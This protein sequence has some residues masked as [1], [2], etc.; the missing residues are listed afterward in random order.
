MK[1]NPLFLALA[2]DFAALLNLPFDPG[3]GTLGLEFRTAR[4]TVRV[5]PHPLEESQF[6]VSVDVLATGAGVPDSAWQMLLR[7][8]LAAIA[9]HGWQIGLE[10]G[11]TLVL[12]QVV[13]LSR[14]GPSGLEK[15]M[16][17]GLDR[18]E[19]LASLWNTACGLPDREPEDA[20]GFA[21]LQMAFLK[22]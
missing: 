16:S 7:M 22:A 21:G 18:A 10:E 9:E 11:G 4:H 1:P 14:C 8:N 17:D 19:A 20:E 12:F 3:E 5:L 13:E 2:A 6:V 15:L